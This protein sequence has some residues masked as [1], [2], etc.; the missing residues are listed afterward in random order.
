MFG[1]AIICTNTYVYRITQRHA[2]QIVDIQRSAFD[3][4]LIHPD[5]AVFS[6]K[7]GCLYCQTDERVLCY[8]LN[9]Q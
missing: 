7:G 8:L 4:I 6:D 9:D 2:R 1:E 3:R 5:N